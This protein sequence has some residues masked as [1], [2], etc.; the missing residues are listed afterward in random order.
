MCRPRTPIRTFTRA[1]PQ[2]RPALTRPRKEFSAYSLWLPPL[3]LHRLSENHADAVREDL[4]GDGE[5]A[6]GGAVVE[7][8]E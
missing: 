2:R 6:A 5:E 7:Q 8:L 4:H 1:R 3:P